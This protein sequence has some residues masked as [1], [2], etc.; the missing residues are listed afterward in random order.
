MARGTQ[1]GEAQTG[2]FR[3]C[4]RSAILSTEKDNCFA[5]PIVLCISTCELRN[6]LY[7]FKQVVC[8]GLAHI[9]RPSSVKAVLLLLS[10]NIGHCCIP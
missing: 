3:R 2:L 1:N 7:S 6:S 10:L 8:S 9:E 4:I 5:T